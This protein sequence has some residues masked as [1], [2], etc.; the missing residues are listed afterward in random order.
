M[1]LEVA[2]PVSLDT[3]VKINADCSVITILLITIK[4]F[5]IQV[6]D[7]LFTGTGIHSLKKNDSLEFSYTRK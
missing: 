4:M 3:L 7:D 2:N 1:L 5:F 6:K